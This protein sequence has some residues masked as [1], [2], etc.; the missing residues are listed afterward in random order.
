M[1]DMTHESAGST[2]PIEVAC[3]FCAGVGKD[4]FGVMYA[5]STCQV[6]GG[7]GVRRLAAPV[8]ECVFCK[9]TGVYPGSR[10]TCTSCG[11]VGQV[12]I[13]EDAVTCRACAGSGRA[14]D[15]YWPDSP[16]PCGR[17]GGKGVVA[18]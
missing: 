17:C 3:A 16:L 5:G 10:L 13:P 18:R 2:E 12:M 7:A 15:D 9:G 11:G 14:K 4:P 1:D 6:C 8:T